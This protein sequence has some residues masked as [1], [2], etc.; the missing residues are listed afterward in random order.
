MLKLLEF[1]SRADLWKFG[2]EIEVLA[3][4]GRE[5]GRGRTFSDAPNDGQTFIKSAECSRVKHWYFHQATTY[6]FS[7]KAASALIAIY[8]IARH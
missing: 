3:D 4:L 6:R 1:G 8:Y 2:V 7:R 5:G